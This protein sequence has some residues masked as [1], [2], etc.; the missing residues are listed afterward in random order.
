MEHTQFMRHTRGVLFLTIAAALTAA[1]ADD[2]AARLAKA[3]DAFNTV[4]KSAHGG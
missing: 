4:M 1:A 2:T 3:A